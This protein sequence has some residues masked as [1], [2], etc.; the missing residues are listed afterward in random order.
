L[1]F[2]FLN[3]TREKKKKKKKNHSTLLLL[4]LY[5]NST[6]CSKKPVFSYQIRAQK[7]VFSAYLTLK[8]HAPGPGH[9][10]RRD[11]H[12]QHRK[13]RGSGHEIQRE[14]LVAGGW[15]LREKDARGCDGSNGG[16]INEIGAVLRESGSV[17]EFWNFCAFFKIFF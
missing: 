2:W 14:I 1:K 8:K 17:L 9:R 11:W 15:Q 4:S 5:Q 7:P 16:K 12:A 13:R 3:D 6:F 10:G